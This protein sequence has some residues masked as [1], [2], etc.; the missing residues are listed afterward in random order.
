MTLF[1][2]G[3]DPKARLDVVEQLTEVEKLV[4]IACSDDSPRVRLVAVSRISE[5]DALM[6]VVRDARELDVRLVAVERISSEQSIADIARDPRNLDLIGMCFSRITDRKIIEAIAEDT[7][8]SKVARRMAVEHY[9]DES[10]LAELDGERKSEE[11]VQAFV[12]AY[13]GGLR[14]VRAIGRFKRSEKALRALGTIAQK[15]GDTGGLAVEYLCNALGSANPKLTQVAMDEL[16]AVQDPE[17]LQTLILAMDNPKLQAPI[18][19]VL[20]RIDTP[21]ARAALGEGTGK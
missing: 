5:D 16:A 1:K 2:D 12:Q 21:E 7:S 11:S 19:K 17:M 4:Q 14:G 3:D 8:C 15:G 6:N 18:H 13:G 20:A 9:A 10:Y